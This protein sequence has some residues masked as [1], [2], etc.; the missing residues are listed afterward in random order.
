MNKE[1]FQNSTSHK[2]HL[3]DKRISVVP[4]VNKVTT[5]NDKA[6]YNSE[7]LKERESK[8]FTTEKDNYLR[9]WMAYTYLSLNVHI[10]NARMY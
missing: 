4:L 10:H 6:I 1:G 3:V 7:K 8:S 9:T 5:E 2:L